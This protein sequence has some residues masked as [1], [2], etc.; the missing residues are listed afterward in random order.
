VK[1]ILVH[2]YTRPHPKLPKVP[3][4]C[5]IVHR[6]TDVE[7]NQFFS[8]RED[9]CATGTLL[10]YLENW[11]EQIHEEIIL[12]PIQVIFLPIKKV[13]LRWTK[14]LSGPKCRISRLLPRP[15]LK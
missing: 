9:L 2:Q 14:Q 11:L 6:L 1:T 15:S 4:C 12:L 3:V 7:K 10:L 8:T 5:N 13:I